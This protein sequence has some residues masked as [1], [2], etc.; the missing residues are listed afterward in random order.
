MESTS[1]RIRPL[2]HPKSPQAQKDRIDY[3]IIVRQ[4][5]AEETSIGGI[6]IPDS[7][8]EKPLQGVVTSTCKEDKLQPLSIKKGDRVMFS[9]HSGNPFQV[10]GKDF[11]IM[12]ES[13]V[14]AVLKP[15][16]K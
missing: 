14:F 3:K 13:D 9:K 2:P 6:I 1:L 7:A 11:L 4:D 15:K 16:S 5:K 12:K 8:K 10:D